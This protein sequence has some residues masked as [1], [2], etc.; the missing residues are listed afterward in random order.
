MLRL[1]FQYGSRPYS[2]SHSRDSYYNLTNVVETDTI[3]AM[4]GSTQ[5]PDTAAIWHMAK[6][7]M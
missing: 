7:A 1:A 6:T 5:K 4:V 3:P 2:T